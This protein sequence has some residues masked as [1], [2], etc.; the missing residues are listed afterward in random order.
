[1]STCIKLCENHWL[2]GNF[3]GYEVKTFEQM[4]EETIKEFTSYEGRSFSLFI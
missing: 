1:M 2:L 4:K 3:P